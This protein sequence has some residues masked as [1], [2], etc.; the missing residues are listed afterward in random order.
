MISMLGND[1]DSYNSF[2]SQLMVNPATGHK[3]FLPS[4]PVE[5]LE[6]Y[7]NGS[8]SRGTEPPTP[9]N[10]F[11]PQIL[12]S[13]RGLDRFL[14]ARGGFEGPFRYHDIGCGFG[15]SVWAMQ[16]LGN[17]ASG[18]EANKQW[19]DIANP[20]CMNQLTHLPLQDYLRTVPETIDVFFSAHVLEHLPDPLEV[21][22]AVSRHMS[23]DGLFYICVPNIH[24]KVARDYGVRN[25]DKDTSYSFPMH[26]NY[27]TPK[28][29][30]YMLRYSGL[31]P[32]VVNTRSL[33]EDGASDED[34][35]QLLGFELFML[36]GRPGNVLAK[37]DAAVEERCNEAYER[38][39]QTAVKDEDF[40][41]FPDL[42][43]YCPT[44][45]NR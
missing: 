1:R 13:M 12:E 42:E 43:Y 39:L 20:H 33:F 34:C 6:S 3:R 41:P 36:A 9:E 15:A 38:F 14:R 10:E 18:N 19:I 35:S 25:Q 5:V 40:L 28:S 31:E 16:Q 4:P 23:E 7:Y 45:V 29:M 11:T 22:H 30:F 27:F 24:S 21:M 17:R 2:V 8:F 37:R 26:L 44:P 32:F